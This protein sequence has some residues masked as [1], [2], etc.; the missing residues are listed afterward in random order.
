MSPLR[1]ELQDQTVLNTDGLL[2]LL[3][4]FVHGWM[5]WLQ[6]GKRG[7]SFACFR[8]FPFKLNDQ[9]VILADF[10]RHRLIKLL[11]CADSDGAGSSDVQQFTLTLPCNFKAFQCV[12]VGFQRGSSLLKCDAQLHRLA[13]K[14]SPLSR[15]LD[16]AVLDV[17]IEDRLV[18][19]E[20]GAQ[21]VPLRADRRDL[22]NERR[23]VEPGD[24]SPFLTD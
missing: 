10:R 9:F 13:G 18:L 24:E 2:H 17:G 11:C 21:A 5:R 19:L 20:F 8:L 23:I 15:P 1:F 6:R 16:A 14:T 7:V 4:R 22:G 12:L 3:A